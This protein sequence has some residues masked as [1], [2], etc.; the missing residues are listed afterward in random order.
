MKTECKCD[1][2]KSAC[3]FKPGWF[4][5]G[6]VKK[7][8]K[9]MKLSEK[10]FFDKYL[11]IDFWVGEDEIFVLAPATLSMSPG[12]VYPYNPKGQCIFF[13]DG[14]CEIHEVKPFECR[15]LNC[16]D[17]NV[18]ESRHEKVSQ[19]WNTKENQEYIEFLYENSLVLPMLDG[20]ILGM[21]FNW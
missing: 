6:E 19:L 14:L 7:A 17:L 1:S 9:F 12:E 8:A 15:E 5:P 13:K 21:M 20:G 3:Q 10:E 11:G 2:C 16:N 4:I 18:T